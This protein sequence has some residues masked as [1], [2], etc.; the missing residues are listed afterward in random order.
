MSPQSQHMAGAQSARVAELAFMRMNALTAG[1]VRVKAER[2]TA[3]S[4]KLKM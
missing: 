3:L 1:A 2:R 4:F